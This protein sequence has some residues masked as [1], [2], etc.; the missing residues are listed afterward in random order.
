MEALKK[1]LRGLRG[2]RR[3]I[4]QYFGNPKYSKPSLNDLDNKLAKYLEFR[5]GFFIEV[6]ANDG[7]LQSNT[8]YLEKVLGWQGVLVEAIP[9]L[10]ERCRKQRKKA[11][12]YNCAL[13][14]KDYEESTIE[15]NFA[16]LMS[17]VEGARKTFDEQSK[18]I[19]DGI[20]LQKLA[21]SYTVRVPARTLESILD[22]LPYPLKIDFFSLD[23][24]GYE[25]SVLKGLNLEKY[26]PKYILIEATFFDEVNSFLA[27]RYELI[28][29]MSYHDYLYR[30]KEN[31]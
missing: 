23:V 8:Y 27:D 16:N 22:G 28:E 2:L 10:Y 31:I 6:G 30:L 3:Q 4:Y 12:V 20:R 15:I 7:Y 1:A 13:V 11:H 17:V 14:A 18:H 29:K 5:D 9:E 26:S 19:A 24:E 25:L 21:K